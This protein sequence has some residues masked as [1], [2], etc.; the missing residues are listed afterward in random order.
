MNRRQFLSRLLT[1]IGAIALRPL[2]PLL[3]VPVPFDSDAFDAFLARDTAKISWV[4]FSDPEV[5]RRIREYYEA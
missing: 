4:M 5:G 3:P 1:A 2:M